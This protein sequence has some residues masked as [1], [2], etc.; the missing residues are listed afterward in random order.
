MLGPAYLPRNSCSQ[1]SN[2]GKFEFVSTDGPAEVDDRCD[3]HTSYLDVED[4]LRVDPTRE[5]HRRGR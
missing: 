1:E 3:V 2:A 4:E 5:P